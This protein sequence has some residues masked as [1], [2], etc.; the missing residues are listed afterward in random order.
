MAREDCDTPGDAAPRP[1]ANCYWLWPGR[2]LAGE[3]PAGRVAE[4]EAAGVTHFVDLTVLPGTRPGYTPLTGRHLAHGIVDFGIPT[5]QGMRRALDDIA[6]ALDGGGA[7]YLHCRAGIGRTGTVAACWLVEQGFEPAEAL[8]LLRRKFGVM[9][10]SRFFSQTPETEAQ[11]A[12]VISW[13][14]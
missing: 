13:S 3:Y 8:A 14:R 10:K 9:E 11:R 7:V 1:H 5:V 4:I 6:A 2:V 12:F